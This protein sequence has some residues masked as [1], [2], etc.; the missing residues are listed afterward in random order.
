MFPLIRDMG[1]EGCDPIQYVKH[2]TIS[3][4]GHLD[5]NAIAGAH[6]KKL[7]VLQGL[8]LR[9]DE[10]IPPLPC[11]SGVFELGLTRWA[12]SRR[13][14]GVPFVEG[15]AHNPRVQAPVTFRLGSKLSPDITS[16]AGHL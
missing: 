7:L 10:K 2:L 4:E 12:L 15:L 6:E 3:L 5:S 14:L 13:A 16:R 1:G 9:R 11:P 8:V